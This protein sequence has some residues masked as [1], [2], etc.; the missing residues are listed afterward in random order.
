MKAPMR[1]PRPVPAEELRDQ[2]LAHV[3]AMVAYWA[4]IPQS[5]RPSDIMSRCEGVAFSI[6][7]AIDGCS[8]GLPAFDLVARPHE[9]DKEYL[10]AEGSDWIEDG[11]VITDTSL[12]EI[13]FK[14]GEAPV[15]AQR[16]STSGHPA[17]WIASHYSVVHYDEGPDGKQSPDA[18]RMFL[19]SL[20]PSGSAYFENVVLFSTSGVHGN[21]RTIEDIEG[22]LNRRADGELT[23]D[24]LDLGRDG[25]VLT[26]TVY[27]PRLCCLRVGRVRVELG[28]LGWL[29]SLRRTS[30]EV[31]ARIGMPD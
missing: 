12:H 19:K 23:T 17:V 16:P 10:R 1:E 21:Y 11:T 18:G 3:R 31:I 5:A 27:Q 24:D 14:P 6:L 13:L 7:T 28:D 29:R 20:F 25:D 2:F 8:M 15:S 22:F 26:A 30:H 4:T 9:D